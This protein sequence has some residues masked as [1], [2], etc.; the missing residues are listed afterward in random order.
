MFLRRRYLSIRS[1]F[2]V[3]T[4][5]FRYTPQTKTAV[6]MHPT[7]QEWELQGVSKN[8]IHVIKWFFS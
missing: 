8:V 1:Q 4:V 2:Q 7:T 3:F 5:F 6:H